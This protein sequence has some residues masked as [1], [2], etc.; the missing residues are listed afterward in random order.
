MRRRGRATGILAVV[1][2]LLAVSVTACGGDGGRADGPAGPA[3]GAAGAP[4]ET[5]PTS[6]PEAAAPTP[7]SAPAV[8]PSTAAPMPTPTTAALPTP[9]TSTP[10]TG[11]GAPTTPTTAPTPG[12]P[13]AVPAE[14]ERCA[15]AVTVGGLVVTSRGGCL[16]RTGL[17]WQASGPVTVAGLA[18]DPVGAARLVV[19]PL[20]ARV[21]GSGYRWTLRG[22]EGGESFE[23][24]FGERPIDWSFQYPRAIGGLSGG[25]VE[26]GQV[27]ARTANVARLPGLADVR[28]L[29]ELRPG[30]RDYRALDDAALAAYVTAFPEVNSATPVFAFPAIG[31]TG[32]APVEVELPST[33]SA[34]LLGLP[35]EAKVALTPQVRGGQGGVL[36][37]SSLRLPTVLR[38]YRG[39]ARVF[40]GADGTL[41]VDRAEVA[42]PVVEL[43]VVRFQPVNLTYDRAAAEWSGRVGA[44]LG[45]T[46]NAPGLTA[47]LRIRNGEFQRIGIVVAGLPVPLGPGVSLTA[48]GG[49]LDV[50]PFAIA[51]NATVQFGPE[52]LGTPAALGV[53]GTT[54]I[55]G[56]ETSVRGRF[57]VASLDLGEMT[58]GFR[59]GEQV[60]MAGTIGLTFGADASVGVAGAVDGWATTREFQMSGQVDVTAWDLGRLRGDATVTEGGVAACAALKLAWFDE[61][62]FGVGYPWGAGRA[63]MLGATCNSKTYLLDVRARGA[64]TTPTTVPRAGAE[65]GAG[66]AGLPGAVLVAART[67]PTATGGPA[68]VTVREGEKVLAVLLEAPGGVGPVRLTGPDGRIVNTATLGPP[69]SGERIVAIRGTGDTQVTVLVAD[70]APGR[71]LVEPLTG[72]PV[73]VVAQATREGFAPVEPTVPVAAAEVTTRADGRIVAPELPARPDEAAS[74]LGPAADPAT[75]PGRDDPGSGTG[76]AAGPQ[77]EDG[78]GDVWLWLLPI[79]LVVVAGVTATVV[80]VRRRRVPADG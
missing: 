68:S 75:G 42:V 41:Q 4:V 39:T 37:D 51:A 70:P 50:D 7:T 31:L 69:R 57:Q 62:R 80:V 49:S 45:V 19:D 48:L 2:G 32:F 14:V 3:R 27:A 38:G 10:G 36:L 54:A 76:R 60:T 46:R 5:T 24:G 13:P 61:W 77:P 64:A 34:Q 18:G 53:V 65:A 47:E 71:W 44:Y 20:N 23:I 33:V 63:D 78:G 58:V 74:A 55:S 67:D 12:A 43:G 35:M 11:V 1:V 26:P 25:D 59:Y 56:T 8:T 17:V 52:I 72:G 16:T 66:A 9:S 6:A 40:V 15:T 29:P 73:A 28:A 21:A 79:G 30:T 22:A